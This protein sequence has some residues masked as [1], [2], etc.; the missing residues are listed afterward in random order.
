MKTIINTA[1]YIV[2][3]L[4]LVIANSVIA[5]FLE[6]P[7]RISP[8]PRTTNSVPHVQIDVR[9][10]PR[11]RLELLKR[12]ANI[13]GVDVRETVVSLPGAK[14]FWLNDSVTLTRP[15]VIVGGREFAHIHPDGSLH[16]SLS[17][18]LAAEAVEMGWA[19]YHPWSHKRA[20]WEG[21]VM[22]YTPQTKADLEIVYQLIVS[23]FEFVTGDI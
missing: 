20:G 1:K 5:S 13:S 14:G 15:E 23:S 17:P 6:L 11:H 18:K 10:N 22:I 21:F 3:V 12:T 4:T 9:M 2:P 8:V 16:A 7:E 19:T